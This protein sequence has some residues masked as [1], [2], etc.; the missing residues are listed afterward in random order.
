MV[1][2]NETAKMSGP[3]PKLRTGSGEGCPESGALLEK[4]KESVSLGFQGH[5]GQPHPGPW[6]LFFHTH[7]L[8]SPLH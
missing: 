2:F 1:G 3:T 8:P 6:L 4:A 7:L 5:P